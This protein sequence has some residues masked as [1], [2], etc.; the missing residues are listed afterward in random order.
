MRLALSAPALLAALMMAEPA[1]AHHPMGGAMPTSFADG[2]LSGLGHPVLGLD[3]LAFLVAIGVAAGVARLGL[4]VPALFVGGS[5]AGVAI[6]VAAIDLPA[7]E[8][9]VAGSVAMAGALLLRRGGRALAATWPVLAAMAGLVHGHAYGEV[10]AGA[11]ATPIF[12]YLLGLAVLQGAM[13]LGLA[14]AIRH[15]GD[16]AQRLV[17]RYAGIAVLAVG[18]LT[19]LTGT[20]PGG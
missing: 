11:E 14:L 5:L 1:A 10:V 17:P 4:L 9:L 6:H 16:A 18:L 2:F 7:V 19:L 12:A 15:A 20:L 8:A 13:M 3:H